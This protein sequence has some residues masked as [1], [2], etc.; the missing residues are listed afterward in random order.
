M[1]ARIKGNLPDKGHGVA[2]F[3]ALWKCTVS[4][5]KNAHQFV[6]IFLTLGGA[7]YV[8]GIRMHND[9]ADSKGLPTLF[10]AEGRPFGNRLYAL[11]AGIAGFFGTHAMWCM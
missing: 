11:E 5:E 8:S 1:A 10:D 6:S 7:L 4:V 2:F 3:F 9:A